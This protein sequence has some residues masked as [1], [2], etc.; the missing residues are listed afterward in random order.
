MFFFIADFILN[1]LPSE[2]PSS[3]SRLDYEQNMNDA[4]ALLPKLHT[5]LD[6]N[7]KFCGV[8]AFE[9]TDTCVIFDLLNISLYHGWLTDP[10]E[11]EVTAAV[12]GNSYNQ[13]VDKIITGKESEDVEKVRREHSQVPDLVLDKRCPL[14]K[15]GL[16]G[17]QVS[18]GERLAVDISRVV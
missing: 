8:A 2:M 18:R 12:G 14:E 7:V 16:G 13:L 6:V 11:T 4:I 10:Q 3:I 17:A 1:S 15:S 9:Y 5:G